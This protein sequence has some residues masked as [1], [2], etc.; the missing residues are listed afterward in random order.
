MKY[1]LLFV[2]FL[3]VAAPVAALDLNSAAKVPAPSVYRPPVSPTLSL[4]EAF[5]ETQLAYDSE[6]EYYFPIMDS[7]GA[8]WAVRF[9]PPQACS[10]AY[11]ELTTFNDPIASGTVAVTI[12]DGDSA[13][14]PATA[15]TSTISFTASGDA[16]RQQIEFEVP[17][18]IGA[19]DFFISIKVVDVNGPHITGD[20]DGGTGRT[21]YRGPTQD[22]DWVEDVDMNIRAYVILYGEDVSAPLI[23]HYPDN[24]AFAEDGQTAITAAV[25]DASGLQSV[26]LYY[27]TDM[28][29]SY[30]D[31]PMALISGLY[32][33]TIPTQLPMTSVKYYIEGTDNAAAHNRSTDPVGG[34]TAPHQYTTLPGRQLKYDDGWPANF[35]I[36]SDIAGNGNAF[37]VLFTPVTY[38]VTISKLRV[39]V[40][41]TSPFSLSVTTAGMG[42]PGSVIAGPFTA[43]SAFAPGWAGVSIPENSQPVVTTGHFFVLLEWISSTPGS[44]GVAADTMNVDG[45]SMWYDNSQGWTSWPYADWM[46]RAVSNSSVAIVEAED[47]AHPE[48]FALAQNYPNPFNPQ[49]TIE[50]TMPQTGKVLLSIYDALGRRV[51]N[52]DMGIQGV[53][54]HQ[55]VWNGSDDSGLPVPSGVYFYRLTTGDRTQSR[56]MLLLK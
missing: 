40:N 28:G 5:G 46:I 20:G 31:I 35:L 54:Q 17:L 29:A 6:P 14:G 47:G 24:S 33:A 10:L 37:A 27:S 22:W 16:S 11:F 3:M 50:Y 13:S 55:V 2:G 19:G 51:R 21:W 36:V 39:Y 4:A 18:D 9:T 23:I 8:E 49:T 1:C 32:R 43:N 30:D 44:P 56:K 53:G 12:Y 52:F 42:Q 48:K 41:D 34:P 45:R 25:S 38:P 26:K 15:L 7:L